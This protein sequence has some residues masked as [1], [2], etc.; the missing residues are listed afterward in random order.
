MKALERY[1]VKE[2]HVIL[3]LN[4]D[5]WYKY[6]FYQERDLQ[7]PQSRESTHSPVSISRAESVSSYTEP[8]NLMLSSLTQVCVLYETMSEF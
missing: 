6:M 3:M 4:F 2:I 5:L 8:P 7:R 1:N